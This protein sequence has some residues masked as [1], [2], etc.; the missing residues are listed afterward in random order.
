M[1]YL[2]H[3]SF[4]Q[5]SALGCALFRLKA[6]QQEAKIAKVPKVALCVMEGGRDTK[7]RS[8]SDRSGV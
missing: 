4:D 3:F 7:V 2:E 5:S 8:G 1:D 6:W